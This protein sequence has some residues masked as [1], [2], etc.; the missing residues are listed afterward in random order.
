M[1]LDWSLD[2]YTQC[3]FLDIDMVTNLIWHIIVK[4][5]DRYNENVCNHI[6]VRIVRYFEI[7]LHILGSLALIWT[8]YWV[9][10]SGSGPDSHSRVSVKE[11]DYIMSMM[12][13]SVLVAKVCDCFFHSLFESGFILYGNRFIQLGWDWSLCLELLQKCPQLHPWVW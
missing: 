11:R 7:I 6:S 2:F 10:I 12:T 13:K 1:F 8:I 5:L 9:I 3:T 4:P